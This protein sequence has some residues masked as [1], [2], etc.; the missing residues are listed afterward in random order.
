MGRVLRPRCYQLDFFTPGNWPFRANPRKQMRH[1]AKCRMY[2]R[3]RPHTLQRF[4]AR[5]LYFG[6]R[7][8]LTIIDVFAMA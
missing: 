1:S 2:A 5:V 4:F 7:F 3:G 6:S 8:A